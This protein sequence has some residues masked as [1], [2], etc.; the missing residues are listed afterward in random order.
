M[1]GSVY[2]PVQGRGKKKRE[3]HVRGLLGNIKGCPRKDFSCASWAFQ[4]SNITHT[5]THTHTHRL[6][7]NGSSHPTTHNPPG[8]LANQLCFRPFHLGIR[9]FN[10]NSDP[11]GS[12]EG[13]SWPPHQTSS[14]ISFT[15]EG[16]L[17]T[18]N[19]DLLNTHTYS[20]PLQNATWKAHRNTK[21]YY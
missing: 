5:H 14:K 6:A 20:S 7:H 15:P 9:I 10:I 2:T 17:I 8:P 18:Q 11:V 4:L 21:V 13:R 3:R 1:D 16:H 12:W 19:T